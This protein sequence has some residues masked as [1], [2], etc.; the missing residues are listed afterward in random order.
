[1]TFFHFQGSESWS[2]QG[3]H[4][5]SGYGMNR[6][7]DDDSESESSHREVKPYMSSFTEGSDPCRPGDHNNPVLG[8]AFDGSASQSGEP[9][10]PGG[11]DASGSELFQE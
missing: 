6:P 9:G 10:T 1:M 8:L 4:S 5:M 2:Q 3:N 7:P 11:T